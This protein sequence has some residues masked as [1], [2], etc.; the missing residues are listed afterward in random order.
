MGA[1]ASRIGYGATFGKCWIQ[2]K[3]EGD[4][5]RMFDNSKIG[6]T[7]LELYHIYA[8]IGVFGRKLRNSTVVFHSGNTGMVDVI[9]K[10]TT[11]SR[12]RPADSPPRQA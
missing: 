5:R 1:D 9:N 4:W 6:I 12:V 8:R 3:Y 7:T 2:E 11:S 10:Q